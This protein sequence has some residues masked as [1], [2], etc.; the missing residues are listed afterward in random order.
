MWRQY[1][2]I[3]KGEFL[4]MAVDTAQGGG[5]Y[6]ALQVLSQ[7]KLDVPLT[8][9]SQQPTSEFIPILN[10]VLEGI[11]NHTG[12]K[13]IIAIERNNG[14]LLHCERL[15]GLNMKQLYQMFKMPNIGA[16]DLQ[17]G[18]GSRYGWDT[19]MST[20]PVMLSELRTA[21]HQNL[22]TVYD[23][24]TY[25]EMLSF[26]VKNG[27]PQAERNA[28]DDLLMA[29]A[30]CWQMYQMNPKKEQVSSHEE[31]NWQVKDMPENKLLDEYGFY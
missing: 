13:P 30:I 17:V 21:I 12:V 31:Y 27:K 2:K 25:A 14:G 20:R 18:G 6:T 19:N 5:D 1:R 28:H 11:S 24:M 23:P 9:H 8:Y 4:I 10:K 26:I 29:L 7:S 3:E 22:I 16:S 15:A